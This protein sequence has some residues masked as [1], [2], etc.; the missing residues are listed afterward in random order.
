MQ[1]GEVFINL[2]LQ[3]RHL[4][5]QDDGS[6]P[7]IFI[8]NI[9]HEQKMVIY[10]W[11]IEQ[12]SVSKRDADN[13]RHRLIGLNYVG[14]ELPEMTVCL[15]ADELSLDYRMGVEWGEKAVTA[16]FEL[17]RQVYQISPQ[18][19]IFQADEGKSINPNVEFSQ[20]LEVYCLWKIN[21]QA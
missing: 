5:E 20:A 10:E 17:L 3:V 18:A 14:V 21:E 15:A 6:L 1:L 12:C 4:F 11:L 8:V 2:W 7:D 9:S 13:F 19:I 16:L